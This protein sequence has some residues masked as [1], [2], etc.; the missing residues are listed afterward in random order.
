MTLKRFLKRWELI[1][2]ELEQ[3][4][5][6]GNDAL[7]FIISNLSKEESVNIKPFTGYIT[8]TNKKKQWKFSTK[9]DIE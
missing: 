7:Q 2:E 4:Q 9:I 5:L 3:K 6:K 1:K 8:I